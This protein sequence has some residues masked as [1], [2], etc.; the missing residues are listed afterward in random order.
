MAVCLR[1]CLTSS[2]SSGNP[3]RISVLSLFVS[4]KARFPNLVMGTINRDSVKGALANGITAEQVRCNAW[5][6]PFKAVLTLPF[7]SQIIAYLKHHAHAQMLKNVSPLF[8]L[9]LF[10]L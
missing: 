3:L 6:P 8:L 7:S 1:A 5:L 9:L 2:S 10:T 4:L